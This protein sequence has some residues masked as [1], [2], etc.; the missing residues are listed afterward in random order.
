MGFQ[1]HFATIEFSM[2]QTAASRPYSGPYQDQD[3]ISQAEVAVVTKTHRNFAQIE[4]SVTKTE[5]KQN[6]VQGVLYA[7]L[8]GIVAGV[9]LLLLQKALT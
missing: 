2:L 6:V 8:T 1:Q 9:V 5:T 4:E 3:T 7:I